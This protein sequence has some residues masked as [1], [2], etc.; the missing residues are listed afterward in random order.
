[1]EQIKPTY[2]EK[3]R[4]PASAERIV[5]GETGSSLYRTDSNVI[6]LAEDGYGLPEIENNIAGYQGIRREGAGALLPTGIEWYSDSA[7][8]YIIMPDLGKDMST[9]DMGG[10]DVRGE[11]NFFCSQIVDIV[12]KTVK[13]IP[14]TQAAGLSILR[15]QIE[16]WLSLVEQRLPGIVG[17]ERIKRLHAIDIS[18]ASTP[19][20]T[21]MI[22]DFTP[23]NVFVGDHS[24]AFIDPWQ[25]ATYRGSFIPSIA[26]YR[27]NAVDIRGFR[28]A[29]ASNEK[30][31]E[32]MHQI[33]AILKL[34]ED[35]LNIQQNLGEILQY[36]LSAYVRLESEP[37]RALTYMEVVRAKIDEI[38]I[39][40]LG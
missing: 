12:D 15:Q 17:Q 40:E 29:Q 38:A 24:I 8:A 31:L 30:L 23:D 20:S 11:Y 32:A 18:K 37:E 7:Q 36:T 5:G 28:S 22:Q 3:F 1:M 35:Q 16:S 34:D 2:L 25:Q 33:A 27:A 14:G 21:V 4:L 26:Q 39:T 9:R 6:K 10:E 13:E 19:I